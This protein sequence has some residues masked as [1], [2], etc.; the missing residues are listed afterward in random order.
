M[1]SFFYNSQSVIIMSTVV[2]FLGLECKTIVFGRL[3]IELRE[4]QF[5]RSNVHDLLCC[6]RKQ[7]KICCVLRMEI[8]KLIVL[9]CTHDSS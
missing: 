5:L 9:H 4:S 7:E 6:H 1:N 2:I 3:K 8:I